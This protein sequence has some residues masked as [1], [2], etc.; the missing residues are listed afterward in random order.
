M[1]E[2]HLG[3]EPILFARI[4][5]YCGVTTGGP[6]ILALEP[7]GREE[8]GLRF[9][10]RHLLLSGGGGM[11]MKKRRKEVKEKI[12]IREK[13]LEQVEVLEKL[14][15]DGVANKVMPTCHIPDPQ[16]PDC[17]QLLYLHFAV[18][19]EAQR[20]AELTSVLCTQGAEAECRG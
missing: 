19:C 2:L 11:G 16:T 7:Q 8:A 13:R 9:H 17:S 15:G 20:G 3:G 10:W 5:W 14:V 18:F 12:Q 6:A 4:S 1:L